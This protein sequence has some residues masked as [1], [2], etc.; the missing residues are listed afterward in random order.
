M[1]ILILKTKRGAVGVFPLAFDIKRKGID[2]TFGCRI[3]EKSYEC[4]VRCERL[5][6]GFEIDGFPRPGTLRRVEVE[7]LEIGK[8]E[9][10]IDDLLKLFM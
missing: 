7:P 5:E 9:D 1:S 2:L 6:K 3:R 4:K 8:T 10:S